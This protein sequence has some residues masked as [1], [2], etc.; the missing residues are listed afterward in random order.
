M[1]GLATIAVPTEAD[2][3]AVNGKPV[4]VNEP[5]LAVPAVTPPAAVSLR[6]NVKQLPPISAF[7][8]VALGGASGALLRYGFIQA[9]ASYQTSSTTSTAPDGTTIITLHK[10]FPLSTFISNMLGCLLIGLLSILLPALL[11]SP[12]RLLHCRSLLVTGCLGALTTMSSFVLDSAELWEHQRSRRQ[13]E[14]GVEVV[15]DGDGR[16][17]V[18]V[19]YWVVTNVGGIGLVV[20]GRAVARWVERR[21]VRGAERKADASVSANGQ[22]QASDAE[23]AVVR[24]AAE[25]HKEQAMVEVGESIDAES[26][27]R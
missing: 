16:Q 12:A 21:Y 23:R 18:G 19:V 5:A 25:E 22:K 4:A 6:R 10:P 14:S 1:A 20:I 8:C 11:P 26:D 3:H 13:G 7:L 17:W 15:Q 2:G 24:E 9:C 27:K